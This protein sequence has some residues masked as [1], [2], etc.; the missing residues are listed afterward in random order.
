MRRWS[1][2]PAALILISLLAL[3]C[4]LNTLG[5][6]FLYDD[7]RDIAEN[8]L[9]AEP[10]H[11]SEVFT[12]SFLDEGLER[13]LYRPVVGLTY[14]IDHRLFGPDPFWFR[15]EN[16]LWHAAAAL[17]VFFLARRLWP[18]EP[19]LALLSASL[20]AVH[21]V[22]TE[23]VSWVSGR[24]EVLAA[25]FG[26]AAFVAHRRAD[27]SSRASS[28]WRAAALALWLAGLGAKEMVATLPLLLLLTDALSGAPEG[29]ARPGRL[30]SRYGPYVA[31]G[32]LYA[33]V[34]WH[35][36]GA[37]G[38]AGAQQYFQ[39]APLSVRGPTMLKVAAGY[40]GRM[41]LPVN[42]NAAWT[43]EH[44]QG[45]MD[46]PG[47]LLALALLLA[48]IILALVLRRSSPPLA[49][50]VF[51]TF[52]ALLPVSNILPVGEIAAERF[53][54]FS[55]VGSCVALGW[56]LAPR[57]GAG[58]LATGEPTD[59]LRVTLGVAV[60]VLFAANT[61]DRNRDWSGELA[62]WTKTVSQSPKSVNARMNLGKALFERG[63]V[64]EA[65]ENFE[66]AVAL[67]PNYVEGLN[68]LGAAYAQMGRVEEAREAFRRLTLIEPKHAGGWFNLG[69]LL[70]RQGDL[71]GA[72][73]ALLK[74]RAAEPYNPKTSYLLGLVA[75]RRRRLKDAE[76]FW[77]ET[78]RL[79]PS[80]SKAAQGLAAV[81]KAMGR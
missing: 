60:V 52:I 8:P 16:L 19:Y 12:T 38:P 81:R 44:A 68:S 17:M 76:R 74:A 5:G 69:Y 67:S 35:V 54:Y 25:F 57:G 62:L 51:W 39:G 45:M 2:S 49:W 50:G 66:A 28:L 10:G 71:A 42:M 18:A 33:G 1:R 47:P 21:P 80:F 43:V 61:V 55:S 30:A 64:D 29:W 13:G 15:L 7:H 14:W 37:L 20:F 27:A 36:L 79:D 70:Y 24:S 59:K 4:Y 53:L 48:L 9:L 46:G 65:A 73:E 56:V 23:A 63:R 34:R 11:L 78:L 31:V 6:P 72:E 75:Y 3:G 58:D 22:H 40:L 26:L 41:V 77:Q 32:A